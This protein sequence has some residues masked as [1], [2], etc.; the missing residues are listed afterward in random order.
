MLVQIA[1][2][3]SGRAHPESLQQ[4]GLQEERSARERVLLLQVQPNPH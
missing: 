1:G 2:S 4:A 3:L